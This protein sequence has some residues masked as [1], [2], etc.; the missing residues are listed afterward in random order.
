MQDMWSLIVQTAIERNVQVFA[1]THSNDC[2]QALS[3][4][5]ESK[6][7]LAVEV[8]VHKLNAG[9]ES[10]VPISG[11]ELPSILYGGAEIR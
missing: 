7:E 6:P 10:S 4:L 2:L 11:P 9:F 1:T 8:A 3:S 5:C